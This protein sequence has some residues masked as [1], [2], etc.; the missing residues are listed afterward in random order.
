MAGKDTCGNN[1]LLSN[2]GPPNRLVSLLLPVG[3]LPD[4]S[5]VKLDTGI[6]DEVVKEQEGK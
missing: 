5:S 2:V 6:G 3:E 1:V 4:A